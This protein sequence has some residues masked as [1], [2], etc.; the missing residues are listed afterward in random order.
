ME[1]CKRKITER[2]IVFNTVST[3]RLYIK[4][5]ELRVLWDNVCVCVWTKIITGIVMLGRGILV[6]TCRQVL[7]DT[8]SDA[9]L[10]TLRQRHMPMGMNA[11]SRPSINP[12][13]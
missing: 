12:S 4:W 7:F 13:V 1:E 11:L 2:L 8:L 10:K 6:N 3:G 9:A 5:S